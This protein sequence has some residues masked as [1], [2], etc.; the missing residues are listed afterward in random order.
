MYTGC[1][2]SERSISSGADTFMMDAFQTAREV[3]ERGG[4]VLKRRICS[5]RGRF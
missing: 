3:E 1:A 5:F 2:Q 4:E